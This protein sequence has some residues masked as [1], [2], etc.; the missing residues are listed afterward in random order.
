MKMGKPYLWEFVKMEYF[1][2]LPPAQ[3]RI[4]PD[5]PEGEISPSNGDIG[6]G[7]PLGN[8]GSEAFIYL[9]N[10]LYSRQNSVYDILV[11][12]NYRYENHQ[13]IPF[14]ICIE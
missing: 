14:I 12:F 3:S 7:V 10:L 2:Y 1:R 6:W 4:G 5:R 8:E 11:F 9:C 13:T